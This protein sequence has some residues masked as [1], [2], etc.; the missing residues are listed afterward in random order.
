MP[1][2]NWQMRIRDILDAIAAIEGYTRDMDFE[3]FRADRRTVHA[4]IRNITVIGEAARNLPQDVVDGHP[5]IPWRLMRDFRNVVVH[6]YFR[7]DE[8][9]VWDTLT[10]DLP[11]LVGPLQRLLAQEQ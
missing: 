5:D 10:E 11:D 4:V 7:V 8:R 3:A 6:A 1:P 2:R 9:I